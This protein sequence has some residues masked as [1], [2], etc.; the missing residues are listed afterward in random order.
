MKFKDGKLIKDG[1][2]P[3]PKRW[4]VLEHGVDIW[5]LWQAPFPSGPSRACKAWMARLPLKES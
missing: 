2:I 5:M 4:G 3:C 1:E